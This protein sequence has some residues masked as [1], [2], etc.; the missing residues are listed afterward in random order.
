[1][2]HDSKEQYN[3]DCLAMSHDASEQKDLCVICLNDEVPRLR[4]TRNTKKENWICCDV[5]KC[6]FHAK[7]GGITA[8]QYNRI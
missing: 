2:F 6:W 5:C 1:M 3:A 4:A 7:C 8:S